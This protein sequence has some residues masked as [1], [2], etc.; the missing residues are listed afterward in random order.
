MK[1]IRESRS[2]F[3][4]FWHTKCHR[5]S[6]LMKIRSHLAQSSP[7]TLKLLTSIL[8][9]RRQLEVASL[10]HSTPCLFSSAIFPD[11]RVTTTFMLWRRHCLNSNS[12]GARSCCSQMG[13]WKMGSFGGEKIR[14]HFLPTAIQ[15]GKCTG[16]WGYEGSLP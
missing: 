7:E 9:E 12:M 15:S 16:S 14:F 13:L 3:N 2:Y 5:L 11:P 10:I 6:L 4:Y 1:N 8:E